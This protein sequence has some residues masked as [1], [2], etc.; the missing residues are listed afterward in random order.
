MNIP[1]ITCLVAVTVAC[2][3]AP[4]GRAQVDLSNVRY[5]NYAPSGAC[6]LPNY[7]TVA[8]NHGT[9][10]CLGGAW[11][12]LAPGGGTLLTGAEYSNGVCATAATVNPANGNRQ[13]VTLTAGDTCALSFVQPA[14]GMTVSIT[15]K[16]TQAATPTGAISTI[17]VRWQGGAAPTITTT[18]GAVDFVSCYLDGTNTWC[19]A[20]QNFAL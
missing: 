2:A 3:L 5:Q 17:A 13:N 12:Q 4:S 10:Q 16:V 1:R 19:A 8:A 11:T 18:V 9:Y 7:L 14:A 20:G 6:S 15:L